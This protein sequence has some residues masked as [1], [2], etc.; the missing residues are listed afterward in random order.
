MEGW[1]GEVRRVALALGDEERRILLRT[2]KA[3]LDDLRAEMTRTD[4]PD[5]NVQL[6]REEEIVLA[7]IDRL[8][9]AA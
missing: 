9:P 3:R 8:D 5:F 7:L 4:S 6:K 1:L 2:L